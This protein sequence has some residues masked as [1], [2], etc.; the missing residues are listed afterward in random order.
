MDNPTGRYAKRNQILTFSLA[1][2]LYAL[3]VHAISEVLKDQPITPISQPGRHLL[4]VINVRGQVMPV[5]DQREQFGLGPRE[6]G[7]SAVIVVLNVPSRGATTKVGLQVDS[8]HE[9]IELRGDQIADAPSLGSIA[10]HAA[11]NSVAKRGEDLILILNPDKLL[12]ETE[13]DGAGTA[14]DETPLNV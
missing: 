11:I 5:V 7:E 13:F 2:H 3:D 9:V 6:H 12:G 14:R 4:G 10:G 1:N 8:V